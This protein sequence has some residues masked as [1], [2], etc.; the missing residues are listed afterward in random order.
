M[1]AALL[2]VLVIGT[3]C[4]RSP[5]LVTV[6]LVDPQ[7]SRAWPGTRL[8]LVEV[9]RTRLAPFP[10]MERLWGKRWRNERVDTVP[11]VRALGPVT[12][13]G[14]TRV[15]GF[16]AEDDGAATVFQYDAF[17]HTLTQT[18]LPPWFRDAVFNPPPEFAPGGGHVIFLAR[19]PVGMVRVEA[20]S[21]PD[22][23]PAVVGL[24]WRLNPKASDVTS[25]GW[26]TAT[27]FS[28]LLPVVTD[29]G[30]MWVLIKGRVTEGAVQL[31]S[32]LRY[33]EIKQPAVP[34]APASAFTSLPAAFQAE[35]NDRGCTLPQSDSSNNW[36][37]G[38]FGAANQEDWAVLCSRRGNSQIVV[39]WGGPAQC[40]REL[41]LAPDDDY[42]VFYG[43]RVVFTRSIHTRNR[44]GVRGPGTR[45]PG[46]GA[47]ALAHGAI[48]ES[49]HN[50]AS[51]FWFCQSG[52]WRRLS[53]MP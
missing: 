52:E 4:E 53:S 32:A 15:L 9:H 46:E 39:Y 48:E 22:G 6:G 10:G 27:E 19:R 51:T 43:S 8:R 21:W 25:V 20:Y 50:A 34:A 12:V 38:N 30:E 24:S 37:Q 13:V 35:L 23:V 42:T 33:S 28:S 36:I 17:S 31:D 41:P 14:E 40:P 44:F 7:E 1:Q 11:G 3:G 49:H 45:P 2:A 47:Q 5:D 26:W 16:H 18:P 29:T